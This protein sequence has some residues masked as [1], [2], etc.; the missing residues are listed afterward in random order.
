VRHFNLICKE[1]FFLLSVVKPPPPPVATFPDLNVLE[2]FFVASWFHS[3]LSFNTPGLFPLRRPASAVTFVLCLSLI[4]RR[5][6]GFPFFRRSVLNFISREFQRCLRSK[7]I[8]PTYGERLDVGPLG[9]SFLVPTEKVGE[10]PVCSPLLTRQTTGGLMLHL[11]VAPLDCF[12]SPLS[13]DVL[14][15]ACVNTQVP[16]I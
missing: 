16:F 9:N 12:T 11:T 7:K 13:I 3:P 5:G 2:P 1:S 8:H 14:A 6:R 10:V 15:R 4:F